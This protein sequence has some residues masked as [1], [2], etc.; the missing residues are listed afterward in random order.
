MRFSQK[1]YCGDLPFPP[2]EDHIL[3]ELSA[4]TC[5]SW[6]TLHGMAPSFIVLYKP[7][8]HDKTVIHERAYICA[9][10]IL[11]SFEFDVTFA[12]NPCLV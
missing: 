9:M 7:L 2:S 1:V 5:L 12:Q 4:M 11:S 6:V 10:V 3:S 8:L